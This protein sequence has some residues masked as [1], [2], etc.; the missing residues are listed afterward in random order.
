MIC[1]NHGLAAKLQ[2]YQKR[3]DQLRGKG[4][5]EVPQAVA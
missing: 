5:E 2:A 4:W 1:T 3:N